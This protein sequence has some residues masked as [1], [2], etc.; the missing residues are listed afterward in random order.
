MVIFSKSKFIENDC[1]FIVI[2]FIVMMLLYCSSLSYTCGWKVFFCY[3]LCGISSYKGVHF[4]FILTIAK[5]L[6]LN[7]WFIYF[8]SSS[9]N[10]IVAQFLNDLRAISSGQNGLLTRQC[11]FC[12]KRNL[13]L[14]L[15]CSFIV[16]K[17]VLL[18]FLLNPKT[19]DQVTKHGMGGIILS[20]LYLHE[21]LLPVF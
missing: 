16:R 18:N 13:F 11:L 4:K 2:V 6:L 20:R 5:L 19:K 7:K 9:F 8:S 10:W 17:E 3:S 21:Q 14:Y 15:K 1:S 12:F